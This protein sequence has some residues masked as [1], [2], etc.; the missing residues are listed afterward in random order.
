[1]QKHARLIALRALV[2]ASIIGVTPA[3]SS[4]AEM[5]ICSLEARSSTIIFSKDD[6]H[7][8]TETEP[9]KFFNKGLKLSLTVQENGKVSL[10][11]KYGAESLETISFFV[12]NDFTE[13]I[14]K[15]DARLTV[16]G[17]AV[18]ALTNYGFIG[19]KKPN[20]NNEG[21]LRETLLSKPRNVETN[22]YACDKV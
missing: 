21:L 10:S 8:E 22:V 17:T 7:S 2:A 14:A 1:M 4:P 5:W 18:P 19:H 16:N 3:L 12:D 13:F 11:S 15:T 9:N 6:V 20:H